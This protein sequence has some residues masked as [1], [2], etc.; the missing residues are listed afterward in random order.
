MEFDAGDLL[1]ANLVLI[2]EAL[3][4]SEPS[5]AVVVCLATW[6]RGADPELLGR[7]QPYRHGLGFNGSVVARV[8]RDKALEWLPEK[9]VE[10]L[11]Q[12]SGPHSVPVCSGVFKDWLTELG[13]LE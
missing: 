10:E 13:P 4:K 1:D 12:R 9:V 6:G 11:A 5:P 8:P 3:A 7:L 2:K